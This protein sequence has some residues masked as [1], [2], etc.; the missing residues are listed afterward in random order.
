M[1]ASLFVQ[2]YAF[3]VPSVALGAFALGLPTPC[4]APGM[5]AI[6]IA[7]H[8]PAQ[9]AYLNSQLDE[10]DA[11][12]LAQAIADHLGQLLA[13]IRSVINVGERLLWGNVAASCATAFRAIEGASVEKDRPSIRTRAEAF[14]QAADFGG[15]AS[16]GRFETVEEGTKN[17]WYWTRTNCCLWYQTTSGSRCDDCSLFTPAELLAIRVA[18][19]QGT[20]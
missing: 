9:V 17:G 10:P 15:F 6:A 4:I 19:L 1:A 12:T 13:A 20:G 3:R 7:R 8:R 16:A 18:Q 11:T 14:F 5:T 2:A